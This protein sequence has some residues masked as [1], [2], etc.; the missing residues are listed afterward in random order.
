MKSKKMSSDKHYR[1]LP[2]DRLFRTSQVVIRPCDSSN[3]TRRIIEIQLF[4][5]ARIAISFFRILTLEAGTFGHFS[6][7]R[8]IKTLKGKLQKLWRPMK[9][10]EN[11]LE[12]LQIIQFRERSLSSFL[13]LN[14]DSTA[15]MSHA[16][17]KIYRPKPAM[18]Q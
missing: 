1:K 13:A 14:T 11:A 4:C 5:P 9:A 16:E 17:M 8:D 7:R 15:A 3:T 12:N 2:L 18:T 6:L 10:P